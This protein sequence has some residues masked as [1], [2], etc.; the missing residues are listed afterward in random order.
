MVSSRLQHIW[1]GPLWL[2][3]FYFHQLFPNASS[4]VRLSSDICDIY[5]HPQ[6]LL[7]LEWTAASS[8]EGL[9]GIREAVPRDDEESGAKGMTANEQ[10]LRP[11]FNLLLVRTGDVLAPVL[12]LKYEVSPCAFQIS[13]KKC[14]TKV[15]CTPPAHASPWRSSRGGTRPSAAHSRHHKG[16]EVVRGQSTLLCFLARDLPR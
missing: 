8:T 5:I 15:D 13:R 12:S 7:C 4:Y 9:F 14:S 2:S 10:N 1:C 11:L 6:P 16:T 3:C